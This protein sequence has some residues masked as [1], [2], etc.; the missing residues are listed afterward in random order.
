MERLHGSTKA[1]TLRLGGMLVGSAL[2]FQ[3]QRG[4]WLTHELPITL[5]LFIT[6]PIST[7][8]IAKV[9]LHRLRIAGASEVESPAGLP[10]TAPC[11]SDWATYRAPQPSS[12]SYTSES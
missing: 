3:L 8:M 10:P 12:R 2:F 4:S 9:H 1:T 5:F 11:G 7:N 6:A